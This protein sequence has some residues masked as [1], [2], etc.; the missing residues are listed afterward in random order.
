MDTVACYKVVP[1]EQDI[2]VNFD[3][4]LN[5]DRAKSVIGE[6]DLMAI[7]EVVSIA[8][9][10]GGRAVL[11]TAGD[12]RVTDSKLVKAALSRGAAEL[13]AV[14]DPALASADAF[15]TAAVLA[16]A[17]RK[18]KFDVALFGEGSS[19]L[20]AQQVG[21]LVGFLLGAPVLNAVS[22]IE[23]SDGKIAIERTLERE[24]EVLEAVSPVVLSTTADINV[25]RIPQLK[26]ILAAGKKPMT[27]WSLDEVGGLP[28]SSVE[29]VSVLAPASIERKMVVY[30]DASAESI[31]A[32]A[33]DIRALR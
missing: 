3:N 29:T 23:V 2:V 1:D 9:A 4:T 25:P 26:D 7:E 13:Y 33:S 28:A 14:V 15:Q 20:Y 10:T 17:L 24:V 27:V 6:Y 11:L 31:R 16:A 5:M 19:D 12:E 8:D 21:S 18:M 22:R 30:E 32:L